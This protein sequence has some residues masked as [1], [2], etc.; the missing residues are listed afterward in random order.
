MNTLENLRLLIA[1]V[2]AAGP[3]GKL[4]PAE[5]ALDA[6]V[7]CIVSLDQRISKLEEGA[8]NET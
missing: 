1:E 2:K 8:K 5:R 7:A 3:F 6:A 4:E